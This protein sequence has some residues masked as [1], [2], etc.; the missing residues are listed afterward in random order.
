M[1]SATDFILLRPWHP[2]GTAIVLS[3]ALALAAY[4]CRHEVMLASASVLPVAAATF[5]F[6]FW[7]L[8][9]DQ[10]WFLTL[11]P[12]IVLVLWGALTAWP[13]AVPCVGIVLLI[14][15]VASQPRRILDAHTFARLPAYGALA[16]GA[17]RIYRYTDEVTA[18]HAEFPLDPTTDPEFLYTILGGRVV[19]E[20]RFSAAISPDGDV[21]FA[22]VPQP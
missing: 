14:A 2:A 8:A 3:I 13:R 9:Y 16:E 1:A 5:G 12:S 4:R 20:G 21:T 22:A 18:I 10:Y 6:S 7:Q 19:P 15:A 17:T 11:M